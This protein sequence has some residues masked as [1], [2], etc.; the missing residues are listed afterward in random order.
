MA[1][2]RIEII[3]DVNGKAIDVAVDS[4]LNLKRQVVELT[5]ALRSAKEGS[6]EF[7][8]LSSRLGD[9]QDS[10]SKT[11]AKSKD[12]FSSLSMLPG[13]IGQFFGQ[14]QGAIE[15]LKTFSSFS[16]KDLNFQFKELKKMEERVEEKICSICLDNTHDFIDR[17][18]CIHCK[19]LF[20][21]SC[22]NQFFIKNGDHCPICR[23][24]ILSSFYLFS[25]VKY[26]L[27]TEIL[28]RKN[29]TWRN[30]IGI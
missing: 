27:Y 23:R 15:L 14:L 8:V 18:I 22:I 3:Y 21:E 5:K 25:E 30:L 7:K 17:A 16:L 20:H 11:T 29:N 2:K 10:L 4:T 26:H 6:D 28:S 24:Y 9:A 13:P 19:H 1:Q 12:L